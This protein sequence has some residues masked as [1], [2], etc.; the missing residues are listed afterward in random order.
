VGVYGRGG[1][2]VALDSKNEINPAR[3]ALPGR[4]ERRSEKSRSESECV[5]GGVDVNGG[6]ERDT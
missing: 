1:V 4:W 3:M 2:G 5:C 6:G